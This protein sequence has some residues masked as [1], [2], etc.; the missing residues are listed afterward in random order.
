MF[1]LKFERS[2]WLFIIDIF[3]VCTKI[4]KFYDTRKISVQEDILKNHKWEFYL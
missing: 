1:R 2:I 3:K 4:S